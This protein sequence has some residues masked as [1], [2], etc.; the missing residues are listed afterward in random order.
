MTPAVSG[1]DVSFR[2]GAHVALA[3]SA[4]TVPAGAIT[5][6]I[7]PNGSGKSTLFDGIAGLHKPAT[8]TLRVIPVDGRPR[9]ISYVLQ[10]THVN[11]AL[12]VTVR[13]VVTMGRYAGA[14]A[15][16]R[17]GGVDRAAVDTAM[18]RMDITDLALRHLGELSGG[19]RQRV[20]IAQGLAQDHDMLLLDEPVTGLD[21]T[22]ARA[23][24]EVIHEENSRGCTVLVTTHDLTEARTA[25]HVLLLAGRVVASGPPDE[26]L[27][28][29]YLTE[30]YGAS[31]VHGIDTEIFLEDP[32]HQ[33]IPGRHVHRDRTIHVETSQHDQHG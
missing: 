14:G 31:L 10:S 24:D 2:F 20:L 26:V 22:S 25:D 7:G 28:P 12:P 11:E 33:P 1:R 5:A 13:E 27:T 29:E 30:A 8:G 18:E 3:P 17:L 16:R 19:Q 6:M 15:Y 23:I 21:V 32:A 9:R 4:F